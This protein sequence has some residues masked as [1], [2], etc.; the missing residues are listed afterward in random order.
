MKKPFRHFRG[1]FANSKYLYNLLISPN[2]VIQDVL[3]ELVYQTLFQWKLE[4]EIGK[5][6]MAMRD[7]DIV[8]IGRIAGV[9]RSFG[10]FL[11]NN[12]SIYFSRSHI[13]DGVQRSERG[14]FNMEHEV[15]EYVR[16]EQDEYSTDIVAEADAG[17]R[18][19][20]V[21]TGTPPV[22]YVKAGTPLF[23]ITG[24]VLWDNLLDQPP[25]DG[26]AYV[27]FFGERFLVFEEEFLQEMYLSIPVLKLM[28]E[29]LQQ[30][31]FNGPSIA[32]FLQAAQILGEGY[33]YDIEI[34]SHQIFDE[35]K[36]AVVYYEA[37][38]KLDQHII[39]GNHLRRY[40][41]W[42]S[43]CQQKFKLFVL[44]NITLE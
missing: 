31:R 38:Y 7:E 28:I 43:I 8:D 13:A 25:Q 27:P 40:A 15:F 16:V 33:I 10:Q 44:N 19:S 29:C 35:K 37:Q 3:D 36:T 30:I 41:A 34:I 23:D 18:M 32:T 39:V 5:G 21:P 14:L 12:G 11:T 2:F 20:V 6:E 9:F 22:G 1:E 4:N 17:R 42:Q 24:E 26:S